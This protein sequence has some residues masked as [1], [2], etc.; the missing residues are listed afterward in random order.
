MSVLDYHDHDKGRALYKQN[1]CFVSA[2]RE[3]RMVANF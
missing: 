2:Q 1:M 3:L